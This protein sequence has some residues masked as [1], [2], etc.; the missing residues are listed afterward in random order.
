MMFGRGVVGRGFG[1]VDCFFNGSTSGI[2]SILMMAGIL[3]L[4]G[5]LVFWLI[6]KN[7][8]KGNTLLEELKVKFVAGEITEEEYLRKKEVLTRK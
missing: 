7:H 2:W 3:V 5:V 1:N 4:I 6:K 8:S